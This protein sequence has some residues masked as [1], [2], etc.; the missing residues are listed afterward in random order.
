VIA[1]WPTLM[2]QQG[3]A[4]QAAAPVLTMTQVQPSPFNATVSLTGHDWGTHIEMVCTYGA[5]SGGGGD[6]TPDELAM[7]I[8]G[9]D[10]QQHVLSTWLG[11]T[12]KT[13]LPAASTSMPMD[14]IDAVRIVSST[15]GKLLLQSHL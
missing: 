6:Q 1:L 11:V 3:E 15:T 12:G 2:R 9:R 13:A 7:V 5:W 4:P 10:G 8:V 14:R